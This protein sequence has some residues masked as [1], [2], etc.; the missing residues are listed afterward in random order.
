MFFFG[1]VFRVYLLRF[2]YRGAMA[3]IPAYG[4]I[5]LLRAY[6]GKVYIAAP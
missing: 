4:G 2:L 6:A 5:S 1:G 3:I